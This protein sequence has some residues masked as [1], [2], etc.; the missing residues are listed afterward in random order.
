MMKTVIAILM[1][2]AA[3]PRARGQEQISPAADARE[4]L[5]MYNSLY[6]KLTTVSAG[7][8]WQASTDVTEEHTG[9]RIGADKAL[10]VFEG[11]PYIIATCRRLLLHKEALDPLSLRQLQVIMLNAAQYPGTIPDVVAARVTAEA[12][13]SA[14]LDGFRFCDE[15]QGDSC[16]KYITPNQIDEILAD[17]T[18]LAVRRHAWEVSKQTG[19][20][21]KPGLLTLQELRNKTARE[22]GYSSF[23]ALQVADYGMTVPEMMDL[24]DRTI[25]EVQPLY[26]QLHYW[27]KV[28]LA[29]RYGQPVPGKIPAHWIGNR[30]SQAWPG[31]VEGVDLD[32]LFKDKTPEWIVKQAE[33]FYVSLGMPGLPQSFWEKSDLYELPPGAPRKKN[34]HASAW[35]I[36]LDHDVRSLMSVRANY[37][38]FETTHH[39]LGHIYYY[40]AYSN[41]GVPVTLRQG[42]NRAFHEA[43]G[44]L[45]AIAA[46]QIPYLKEIGLMPKEMK[47]DQTR[48]L[49][50][51]ALDNAIVF[52]PWS[53]GTMSHWEHDLYE[54]NLP[55]GEYNKRWWEYAAKYQG[56]EPPEPRGEE[57]CDAATKTHIN[58]DPAQ[59]YDYT[60]AFLIKYQLHNYIA[61]HILHQ[62]PHNCNYYG[63]KEVG[64]WL[65]DLLRLGAT[66]DWREVIKE[67]TGEEISPKGMLEYFQPVMEFLQK[68]NAG[69]QVGWEQ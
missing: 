27:A 24:L 11:D 63:N 18:N 43:I 34:T 40:L 4:F 52:I 25:G 6:Q 1:I 42:A 21:L 33:R 35:H 58:D 30:W 59:Y 12:N 2:S 41:P 66:R 16:L 48:W 64:K 69:K 28:K 10:A 67:K 5:S 53:A 55:P 3:A 31:I 68:E 17:S 39:E 29:A 7:S 60:L 57:Y 23:F 54:L 13:Q 62:D 51:E 26:Q 37:D 20:A 14:V 46:R 8:E 44:D 56:V 47:I 22:M 36:D 38:W 61:R 19:P 15:R 45:I 65:W 49:L 32:D 9:Q 50:N